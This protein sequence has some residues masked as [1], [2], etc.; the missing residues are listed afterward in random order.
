M[1]EPNEKQKQDDFECFAELRARVQ[2]KE[3][4]KV[5]EEKDYEVD[6]PID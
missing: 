1:I 2:F 6:W 5:F 3:G 4:D